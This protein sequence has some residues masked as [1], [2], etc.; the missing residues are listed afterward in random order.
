MKLKH[1]AEGNITVVAIDSQTLVAPFVSTANDEALLNTPGK[2]KYDIATQKVVNRRYITMAAGAQVGNNIPVTITAFTA[3]G[4]QDATAT[5]AVSLHEV[6]MM[7][8]S[9][10]AG[11][12]VSLVAGTAVLNIP[13]N[14]AKKLNLRAA[15]TGCYGAYL[16]LTF[17]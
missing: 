1:D 14:K 11:S 5:D 9:A 16:V 6:G 8:P 3:A 12:P 13:A 15:A 2:Y 7:A 4:A 17:A 10:I